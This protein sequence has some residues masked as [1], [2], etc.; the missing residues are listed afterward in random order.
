MALESDTSKIAYSGNNSTV[1]PYVVPFYFFQASDLVVVVT[2]ED[3]AEVTLENVTDYTVTGAGNQ[4]GGNVVTVDAV[5]STSTVTIYRE[6][7]ATQPVSFTENSDFPAAINER[8]VDRLTMLVQQLARKVKSSLRLRESD[9]LLNAFSAKADSTIGFDSSKQV[10]TRTHSELAALLNYVANSTNRPTTSFAD[11]SERDAAM[12][13]FDGQLGIQLDTW[14][15]YASQGTAIGSWAEVVPLIQPG[16]IISSSIANGAVGGDIISDGGVAW[17]KMGFGGQLANR[18][19]IINGKME[20]ATRG[21]SFSAVADKAYTLDRWNYNKASTSGVV[22]ISQQTDVPSGNEFQNSLRVAVT[23]ADTSVASGDNCGIRQHI[24]GQFAR[25]LIGRTFTLSFWVRSSKTGTHCVAFRNS[26]RDRSYIGFYV[27]NS[28]DIWQKKTITVDNGL[29][30]DGTWNWGTGIGLTV[31]FTLMAGTTFHAIGAGTW[32]TGNYTG[33]ASQVN[34]MDS[35]SNIFAVTG[36][37]LEA[38][39]ATSFE[40]RMD[41]AQRCARY[42]QSSAQ[43]GDLRFVGAVSS[44]YTYSTQLSL[45]VVMR[46]SPTVT[47]TNVIGTLFNSTSSPVANGLAGIEETRAATGTSTGLTGSGIFGSTWTASAELS[48]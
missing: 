6:I 32:L 9:P 38:G 19:K 46:A 36:V 29:I 25:D 21:T 16:S 13:A 22:T 33:L 24:E 12:P 47:G 42:Y 41:E 40:H 2:D 44:G 27:I 7:A 37:Q 4:S 28:T 20:I 35:T 34:C 30:T 14:Q 18:N 1:T 3:G 26:G 45:P 17:S 43:V 31:E 15:L 39:A 11:I 10:V 5:P 8:V 48:Y 23:T